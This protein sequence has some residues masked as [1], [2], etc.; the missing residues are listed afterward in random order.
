MHF[1]V[2]V[3]HDVRGEIQRFL[4]GFFDERRTVGHQQTN[5]EVLFTGHADVVGH[6]LGIAEIGQTH[7]GCAGAAC[8]KRFLAEIGDGDFGGEFV[9]ETI[10]IQDWP[11]GGELHQLAVQR[12]VLIF[13]HAFDLAVVKYSAVVQRGG[14]GAHQ[15]DAHMDNRDRTGG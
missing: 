5:R 13:H 15:V 12:T 1:F 11:H 10:F 14:I 2:P 8:A 9:P 3:T 6:Q 4:E 7:I